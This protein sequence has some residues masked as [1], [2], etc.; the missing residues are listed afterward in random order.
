[1]NTSRHWMTSTKFSVSA[2]ASWRTSQT[3]S[4][5]IP[6]STGGP[7]TIDI[8]AKTPKS[9]GMQ[10]F[11]RKP[12]DR[13]IAQ[14]IRIDLMSRRRLRCVGLAVNGLDAHPLHQRGD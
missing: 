13:Q 3:S 10:A 4:K 14:E 1:M 6:S 11:R 2:A 12:Y 5:L 7:L 8:P 9:V